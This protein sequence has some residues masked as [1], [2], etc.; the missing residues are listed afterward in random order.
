MLIVPVQ[1]YRTSE[2][3]SSTSGMSSSCA[4]TMSVAIPILHRVHVI[5]G[6]QS[7]SSMAS[8]VGHVIAAILMFAL[9]FAIQRPKQWLDIP[10]L[11][12]SFSPQSHSPQSSTVGMS[13]SSTSLFIASRNA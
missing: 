12:F 2:R 3:T 5:S 11:P 4:L 1:T 6:A 13:T 7:K 9:Y 8:F 10:L